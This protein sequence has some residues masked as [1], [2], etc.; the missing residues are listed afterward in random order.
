MVIL[1]TFE[2][3]RVCC[4]HD[5]DLIVASNDNELISRMCNYFEET[6]GGAFEYQFRARIAL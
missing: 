4:V 5:S 6:L 3:A 2:A 1:E